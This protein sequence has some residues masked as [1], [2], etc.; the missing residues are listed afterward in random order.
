MDAILHHLKNS[1]KILIA[2]HVNPDGDAIGS[3]IA[4]GLSL[5]NLNKEVT[6]YTESAIPA[7]YQF[8]PCCDRVV[9]L[10]PPD[11]VYDTAIVLDCG[12]LGRTGKVEAR[13]MKIPCVINIDHHTTNTG[14]GNLQ[15]IDTLACAT[16][17]LVYLLIKKLSVPINPAIAAAIYTGI[18][19]DT[20]SFRFSN[21]N[22]NAFAIC[23]KMMDYDVVPYLISQHV[24]G[25]YSLGRIKLLNLALDTIEISDNG[26]MSMMTVTRD[27][28]ERTRTSSEDTDGFINYAKRVADIKMAVLI[29]EHLD[30][31]KEADNGRSFHISLRSDGTVDV[32]AIAGAYGG[33]GHFSAAGFD[34]ESGLAHIKGLIFNIAKNL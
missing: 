7:V 20:G 1:R 12:Q 8:L 30:G 11:A 33:G 19:T 24:Y 22:K 9:S 29:Q 27:M 28:Y 17:E 18:L 10:L 13:L 34:M 15:L 23:K 3:L 2:T 16:A 6:F 21:T 14:F 5:E 25:T 26:K 4:M 32:A 31:Q